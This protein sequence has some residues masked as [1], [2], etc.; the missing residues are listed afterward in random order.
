M[1]KNNEAIIV[2]LISGPGTG[3]S[4]LTTEIFAQLKRH[5]IKCEISSEYYKKKLREEAAK[6]IQNQIY[7]FGK[8]QFQLFT[9][10]DKVDVIVTDSPIIFSAIYNEPQCS[11]LN[12]LILKE[13]HKYNNLNYYIERDPSVPYEQEGRYQDEAG[14]KLVDDKVKIFLDENKIHYKTLVGIGKSSLDTVIY[15]VINKLKENG[16]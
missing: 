7:V 10:K 4:I 2:N 6:V 13:F 5:F 3:K 15:D 9:L 14:A 1:K 12:A 11:E 8:Q 16:K